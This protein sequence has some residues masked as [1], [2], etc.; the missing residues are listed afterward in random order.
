MQFTLLFVAAAALGG[1]GA[2]SLNKKWELT[3]DSDVPTYDEYRNLFP[4][5]TK[6]AVSYETRLAIYEKNV[7]IIQ[8]HNSKPGVSWKMGL[9][10][11]ADMTK[12]EKR[13]FYGYKHHRIEATTT[14]TNT[15]DDYAPSIDWREEGVVTP[16]KNQGSCGS[17]WAF[18]G[19]ESIESAL[20]IATGDLLELSPQYYVSCSPNP[21]D[22]GG[23]GGCDGSTM[24]LLFTFA[25]T[26]GAV[27]E[28]AYPYE[29][30]TG[31]CEDKKLSPVA[32]ISGYKQ[33]G[34]NSF[35]DVIASM[36]KQPI[37][38]TVAAE[39]WELYSSGIFSPPAELDA[40]WEL[41]HGVQLV[42]YQ[43][44][45][46]KTEGYYLVRNSWGESWG[47][48]G[49]IRLEMTTDEEA[50]CGTDVAPGDGVACEGEDDPVKV[51]GTSGILFDT[52]YPTGATLV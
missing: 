20:A 2:K 44:P 3:K 16:V 33:N 14:R 28:E 36:Q 26:G 4:T 42:G 19:T 27:T 50:N 6:S 5:G 41:D 40:T 48:G 21:D 13:T 24:E 31:E 30:V 12:E 9:N 47:E 23:T 34:V 46:K 52:S 32:N 8:E 38:V 10:K 39:P 43:I 22:C 37:S 15:T 29:G 1:A 17:C 7:A 45:D 18:S 11:F 25:E 51:C 35:D 49:Y